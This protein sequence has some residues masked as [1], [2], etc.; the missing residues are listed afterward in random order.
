MDRNLSVEVMIQ[1]IEDVQ[2]FLL[3]NPAENM[4]L[5][6]VQLC[7]HGLI[8]IS[9]TGGLYKNSTERWNLK[10]RAIRQQWMEFKT[11][12]IAEYEK[13]LTA[14]GGTTMGQEGYGTGGAY[15]AIGDN[16]SSLEESI[17]QYSERAT[18]AKGKVSEL[19]SRLAALEMGPPPTQPQTGYYVPQMAYGMMPGGP[20]PPTSI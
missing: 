9:K 16:G 12:F 5:T 2:R 15:N 13:T 11:H 1:D 10:D 4:E 20:P 17:V 14:N 18:Q 3:A 8:K 6:D 7:T 19:E